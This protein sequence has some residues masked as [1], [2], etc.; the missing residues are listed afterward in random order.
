MS[1]T[2]LLRVRDLVTS[3]RTEEGAARVVD[4]VSFDV[5]RGAAVALV[6]ESACGKT[7]TA[8]SILRL[9]PGPLG[10][11]ESGQ[12]E[13]E[14]TDL[15]ALSESQMR[16][17]RGRSVSMVFQ[18]SAT[19]LHPLYTV[20]WQIRESIARHSRVSH[21][22]ARARVRELLALVRLSELDTV[23]DMLPHRLSAGQRQRVMI[24][25][26]LG[27]E[28]A[29]LVL[30]DPASLLDAITQAQV[31]ELLG[32]LRAR[33]SMGMLLILHDLRL[34]AG[35]ATDVVVMCAGRVVETASVRDFFAKQMHPYTRGLIES[36]L[37]PGSTPH[38]RLRTIEGIVPDGLR[39]G[40]GCRF[41]GRCPMRVE[42]CEL[43]EPTLMP[44]ADGRTSRCWRHDEVPS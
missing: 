7:A 16:R 2:P 44:V 11:I 25:M 19:T 28:P 41:A 31:L 32:D 6:G 37:R 34:V 39:L 40:P 26:A 3:Y 13:L 21:R 9:I 30:D 35:H 5:A 29:L 10:R 42:R 27:C 36:I 33:T 17:V 1:E 15:L 8:L 22:Q 4:R 12:I 43:E 24:A 20:G 14:G 38:R 23:V 18:D